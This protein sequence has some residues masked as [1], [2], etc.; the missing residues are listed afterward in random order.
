MSACV[1]NCRANSGILVT[2][3][4]CFIRGV[5][6]ESPRALAAEKVWL[7]GLTSLDFVYIARKVVA[8]VLEKESAI[9]RGIER[10]RCQIFGCLF[11]RASRFSLFRIWP[12]WTE[13]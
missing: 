4:G 2:V 1:L 8:V 9:C 7:T 11:I 6:T 3:G 12:K 13:P 5:T 10:S